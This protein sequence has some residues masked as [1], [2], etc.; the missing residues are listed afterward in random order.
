MLGYYFDMALRGCRRG[1]ALTA[2]VI[3]LM[4][5]DVASRM[6]T[7]AVFRATST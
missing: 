1:K 6:V 4:R 7:Y 2:L 5:C 3:V